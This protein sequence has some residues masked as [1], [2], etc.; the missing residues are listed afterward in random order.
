[1]SNASTGQKNRQ[2]PA[3]ASEYIPTLDGWR[4]VAILWV[5]QNHSPQ[6][7]VAGISN[8]WIKATGDRGVQLF[9]ALSGLLICTRLL[10]E[11]GRFGAISLGSFYTRR[12]F[13]I[14]PAA[15]MYL[16]VI[17]LLMLLGSVERDWAGLRDS[18][19][20]VRNFFPQTGG[21]WETKHFWS[22]AAEEHFYIFLPGFLV[23]CRRYRL[24][25]MSALV[26]AFELWRVEVFYHPRLQGLTML[27]YLRTDMVIGGILLG[28]VFAL[29]LTRPN[30]LALAKA[31]LYPWVALLYTALVFTSLWLHDSRVNH[32]LLISVYPVLITATMVHPGSLT[33]RVLEWAPLRFVGRISFS[34]YLWQQLFLDP[35]LVPAPHSL[36]ANPIV[37]WAATFACAIASFYL[38]ETPLIRV[39]HRLAKKVE[40]Q[41]TRQA[42]MA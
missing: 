20:M 23:L 14:Q 4:A 25:V 17:G 38:V 12:L 37:C 9:F 15:L 19:L 22:L 13:R 21:S 7:S 34:L 1:M 3:K 33:S 18:V 2:K 27:I 30:L 26:V 10:R 29:A 8:Y 16:A 35:F 40:Q 28:C 36:R 11:E 32:A 31:R 5:M 42:V 24:A 41:R 6:W 39:G